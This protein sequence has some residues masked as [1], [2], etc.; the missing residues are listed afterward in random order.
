M[1][2]EV[3]TTHV[4]LRF[5][6]KR[7]R[8]LLRIERATFF[9]CNPKWPQCWPVQ[10]TETATSFS[11]KIYLISVVWMCRYSKQ[12]KATGYD[13]T[14]FINE[15]RQRHPTKHE[16]SENDITAQ[17]NCVEHH[18]TPHFRSANGDASCTFATANKLF[19]QIFYERKTQ[20]QCTD[21]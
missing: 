10:E 16:K 13:L 5:H 18:Q 3:Q 20:L 14:N 11:Q 9:K 4:T 19:S 6:S 12:R 7:S 2:C 15:A 1:Y 17:R 21:G 8:L